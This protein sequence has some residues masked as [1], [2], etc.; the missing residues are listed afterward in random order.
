MKI[1]TH[2]CYPPIPIRNYDWCA[3]LDGYEPGCLIGFGATEQE[4]VDDL[5]NQVEEN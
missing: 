2:F 5:K 1:D 3:T 4:A